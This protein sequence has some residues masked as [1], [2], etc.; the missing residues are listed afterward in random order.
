VEDSLP[1]KYRMTYLWFNATKG[2]NGYE[3][4]LALSDDLLNWTFNQGGD[5]GLVF[6]RNPTPGT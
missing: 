3:V 4:G 6:T 5:N 2:E 1:G